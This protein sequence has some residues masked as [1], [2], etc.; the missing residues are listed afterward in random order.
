MGYLI[1]KKKQWRGLSP[2]E[3]VGTQWWCNNY[4]GGGMNI[5]E[6]IN[7]L[8]N[9]QALMGEIANADFATAHD[10]DLPETWANVENYI[11]YLKQYKEANKC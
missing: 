4:G 10:L 2:T 1:L 9:L 3:M 11:T 7:K 5:E 6:M 8:E